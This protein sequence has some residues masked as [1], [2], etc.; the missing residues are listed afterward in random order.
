MAAAPIRKV[1]VIGLGRMGLPMARHLVRAGFSVSGFD[2]DPER[3]AALAGV[4]GVPQPS[5]GAVAA[6]SDAVLVMVADDA[7]VTEA[8][9]GA[10]GIVAAAPR[11]AVVIVSST[12]T[13]STCRVVAATAAK[14]GVAVLDAPVSLGQRAAEAGTL[15]VFAGG[16][17]DVF[18][19]C[20]PV[21]SA[22]G[23]EIVHVGEA[24]GSGQVAKLVNN[25][26]LWAGI[27][28]VREGLTLGEHL[29]VPPGR[30]QRALQKGSADSYA[31]RALHL[32]NLTWPQKDLQQAMEVAAELGMTLP[33]TERV[34]SLMRGL[35]LAELRRLCAAEG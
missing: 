6:Q 7:Q 25:L 26:I 4:G 5:V 32:I 28:A 30:L 16:P 2:L 12:V 9:L 24:V 17:S 8:A 10:A 23:T 13:P 33:L 27:I 29:G 31:L 18:A 21:L 15:T 11:G 19:R 14:R 34:S 22:F 35:T 3:R 20:R 1:G